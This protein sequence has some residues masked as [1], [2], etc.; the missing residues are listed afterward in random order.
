MDGHTMTVDAVF[1]NWIVGSV[2]GLP[3]TVK[4]CDV[5]SEY[6][7]DEGRIIKLYLFAAD[8]EKEIATYERGWGKY[9]ALKYE[10]SMD[11]LI[12]YCGR[13]PSADKWSLFFAEQSQC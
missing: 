5:E 2:D 13:L 3:Y 6:G 12:K 9:P 7:I 4:V 8:G 1:H 11:A 10:A